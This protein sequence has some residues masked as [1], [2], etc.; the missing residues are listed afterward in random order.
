MSGSIAIRSQ[1][2]IDDTVH[3]ER[4]VEDEEDK[5]PDELFIEGDYSVPF[6]AKARLE[7][8]SVQY[9]SRQTQTD[10]PERKESACSLCARGGEDFYVKLILLETK[11]KHKTKPCYGAGCTFQITQDMNGYGKFELNDHDPKNLNLRVVIYDDDFGE[12]RLVGYNDKL[13]L[14]KL[15]KGKPYMEVSTAN[16]GVFTG[17][18]HMKMWIGEKLD[19]L[20]FEI[21]GC[22]DIV[23]EIPDKK[24]C[25][26]QMTIIGVFMIAYVLLYATVM[27]LVEKDSGCYVDEDT[28]E[29]LALQT[30]KNFD[31]VLWFVLVT[32]ASVGYGDIYPCTDKA[33]VAN[34]V[35]IILNQLTL[36]WLFSISVQILITNSAYVR[37]TVD[38]IMRKYCSVHSEE[39][40]KEGAKVWAIDYVGNPRV[41]RVLENETKYDEFVKD[42][43]VRCKIEWE[44]N[45]EMGQVWKFQQEL[46][47][48]NPLTF[49]RIWRELCK[50]LLVQGG[51]VLF[52]CFVGMFLFRWTEDSEE[53][54]VHLSYAQ[55]FHFSIVTMS[56]VGY[57][58]WAPTSRAGR[59][60]GAF[61]VLI[62]V[63]LLANFAGIMVEY[64]IKRQ[65][66]ANAND[67]LENSLT[68][69]KQ[70]MLFDQDGDKIVSKYEYVTKSLVA[71]KFVSQDKIDLIMQKF[72]E[73]DTD[74]SGE[75]DVADF[76][77][78]AES[79][80]AAEK[81]TPDGIT[82]KG[83]VEVPVVE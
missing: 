41:A 71:C 12:D 64:V 51:A 6:D 72:Y 38:L 83:A 31:N 28:G 65:E 81:S 1:H 3:S 55:T 4:K 59:G 76:K 62:G 61:F 48:Y 10:W 9:S 15:T 14:S 56:T 33:R 34:S 21:L 57:G 37:A 47:K 78:Y 22:S 32:F 19:V 5:D 82:T 42:Y 35:F 30:W 52:V 50:K 16:D 68:S 53:V 39:E 75:I 54:G 44:A 66:L 80:K 11:S 43:D 63:A 8:C 46:R 77:K 17:N 79:T 25:D 70:L 24:T 58:D 49:D 20:H 73:I 45:P 13:N 26:L 2:S 18:V 67:F 40:F 36:A 27:Y 29:P 69:P 23:H 60:I 7:L 74:N